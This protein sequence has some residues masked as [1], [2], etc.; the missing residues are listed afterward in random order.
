MVSEYVCLY[1]ALISVTTELNW[2]KLGIYNVRDMITLA[3]LSGSGSIV[4]NTYERFFFHYE[5]MCKLD[6]R[7]EPLCGTP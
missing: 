4:V 1:P 3:F 7:K 2:L 6:T 5:D